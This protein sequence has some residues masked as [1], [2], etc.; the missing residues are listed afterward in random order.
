MLLLLLWYVDVLEW[1]LTLQCEDGREQC[2]CCLC[3]SGMAAALSKIE[4]SCCGVAA[5]VEVQ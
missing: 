2:V 5:K 4:M 3:S 1:S